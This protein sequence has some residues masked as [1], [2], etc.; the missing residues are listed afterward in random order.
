MSRTEKSSKIF[1][2]NNN[3]VLAVFVDFPINAMFGKLKGE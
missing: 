2:K 1:K 3:Y